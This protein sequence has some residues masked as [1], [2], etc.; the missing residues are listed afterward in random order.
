MARQ[1][2]QSYQYETSPRKLQPEYTPVK[3]PKQQKKKSTVKKQEVKQEAKETK[4][5]IVKKAEIVM[6]IAVGFAVLFAISY[7]NSLISETFSKKEHLKSELGAIEKENEQLSVNI[8]KSLNLNNVEQMAREKLGMQKLTND[9][10]IYISLPKKDYIESSK[11][12]YNLDDDKNV[13]EKIFEF[14]N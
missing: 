8:E 14:F 12:D 4:N 1:R 10:K 2:Y 11:E 6:T 5:N 3:N 9:Q 13:F 7:Q